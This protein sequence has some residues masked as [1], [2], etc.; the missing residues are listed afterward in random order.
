MRLDLFLKLSRLVVRRT[1]AAQMCRAG[2]VEV[3][4]TVAKPSCEMRVGDTIQLRRRGEKLLCRVALIPVGNVPKSA[5][6][7]LYE[8]L[9]TEKY[10]ETEE[11]FH[12]TGKVYHCDHGE[13]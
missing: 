3:N 4:G 11:I 5:A 10:S 7:E 1:V 8:I 6:S 13:A 9:A 2:A 12:A